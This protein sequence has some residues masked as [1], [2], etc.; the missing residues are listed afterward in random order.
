MT[1]H[2][3]GQLVGY[4]ILGLRA[5]RPDVRWYVR[6]L[7]QMLI[8]ALADLGIAAGRRD[9]LTGVWV[10]GRKIALDRR[11]RSAAG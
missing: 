10:G 8:G 7:E 3:P 6:S 4:P 2:G 11:R 9:G 1:Y 5:L